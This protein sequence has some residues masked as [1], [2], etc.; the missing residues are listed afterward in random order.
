MKKDNDRLWLI[1]IILWLF[2]VVIGW[3]RFKSPEASYI[4]W[5]E[6]PNGTS[7]V[8]NSDTKQMFYKSKNGSLSK[9]YT[10]DGT[11]YYYKGE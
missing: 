11:I 5:R 6:M 9:V 3:V 8:Y 4:T 2:L 1:C 7:L 10:P